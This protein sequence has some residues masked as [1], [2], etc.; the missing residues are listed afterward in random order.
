MNKDKM[1]IIKRFKDHVYGKQPDI[2]GINPKHSGKD[3]HWLEKQM[4]IPA[5]SNN[6]PD[7]LGYEMKN[8]TTSKTSFGDWSGDY[9]IFKDSSYNITRNDF[10]AIFGKP[11]AD[12]NNRLSWSGDP[13]PTVS[14]NSPHNGSHLLVNESGVSIIYNFSTDPRPN[15]DILVPSNLQKDNLV[16]VSWSRDLLEQKLTRKFSQSGWFRCRK[17]INGIYNRIEF[18]AP[19]SFD[20]WMNLV[21]QGVIFFDSGMYAGN[22]RPYSQWRASNQYWDSLIVDS[23][24]PFP[25]GI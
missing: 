11:N 2:V 16:L 22:P 18:G 15:K 14:R 17:D 9:Y 8:E 20:N 21:K 25:D 24:P 10:L 13:I 5:N 1:I 19:M 23:Y 3:G 6:A 4:G 12:K 7:L